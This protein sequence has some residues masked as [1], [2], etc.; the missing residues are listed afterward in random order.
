MQESMAKDR[1]ARRSPGRAGRAW[2]VAVGVALGVGAGACKPKPQGTPPLCSFR[3]ATDAEL[4]SQSLPP[5]AWLP[6]VSPSIDRATLVRKGSFKDAC[7]RQLAPQVPEA[8][9][10]CPPD[11][12]AR[13]VSSPGVP[14]S[15]DTLVLGQVG[16]GRMLAWAATDALADGDSFGPAALVF[17]TESGLDIHA[18]GLVRASAKSARLRMHH[19]GGKPVMIVDSDRCGSEAQC[20][21]EVTFVPIVSRKFRD[22]PLHDDEGACLGRARFELARRIEQPNPGGFTRRF[23]LQRTVELADEGIVLVDLVTGDEFDPADPTG[24]VRPFRRVSTRRALD[25]DGERFVV[26]DKDLWTH[27]LRDYGLVREDGDAPL[28]RSDPDGEGEDEGAVEIE[29]TTKSK[30]RSKQ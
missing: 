7:G 12:G 17:W 11:P 24:T 16:Q 30:G 20:V 2:L 25:F 21:P 22:V 15:L 3:A 1:S 28:E 4:A 19:S 13:V 10:G 26:R 27:V 6:I 9:P 8:F 18:T 5:E 29:K 23:E 14:V